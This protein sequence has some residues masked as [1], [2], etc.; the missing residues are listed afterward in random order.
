MVYASGKNFS[1]IKKK[2]QEKEKQEKH[3]ACVNI[4]QNIRGILEVVRRNNAT[5]YNISNII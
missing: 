2:L 3:S 5:F 1:K 4:K